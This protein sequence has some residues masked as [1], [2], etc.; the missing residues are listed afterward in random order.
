MEVVYVDDGSTDRTPAIIKHLKETDPNVGFIR[1]SRNFGKEVAVSAGLNHARG[2]VIVVIDADLQDPP[3][4][5]KSMI[6]AWRRGA[7]VVNMKRSSRAGETALKRMT[8]HLF[9]RIIN[10]L[11]EVAIPEDVGDFRLLSRRAVDALNRMTERNRFMKGLFAWIGFQQETLL[12]DRDARA[13]GTS[14][15][16]YWRLWKLAIEGVTGFST[17]PLKI[18]LYFGFASAIVAFIALAYFLI[19]TWLIG[20]PVPGFPATIVTILFLG[21]VQLASI[22]VLGEYVARLFIESKGR[23]LYLIDTYQP[24]DILL[25]DS[26]SKN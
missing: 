12:Y 23:P 9:Y 17:A 7:D 1:F 3:E 22:G 14:K 26:N 24:A 11:S 6:E 4:L 19:K 2:D 10:R 13:A 15:W 25:P 20:D 18:S 8:A 16:P 5:I 21:G